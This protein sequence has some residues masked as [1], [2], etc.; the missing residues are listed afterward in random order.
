M[1]EKYAAKFLKQQGYK[2]LE[3]NYRNKLGE[4]DLIA[5]DGGEIVF[6]EVKA[7]SADP[8]LSGQYAVDRK[9][10]F[11]ILRTAARYLDEKRT[12][13]QPRFDVVEVEID[14]STGKL[15]K[16]GHF[17]AAFTQTESYARF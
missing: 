5:R 8:Y 11:H 17:R 9:K 3:K 10:Q 14:R 2:I 15:V 16:I 12:E 13:L 6:V 7:R 1:G 4:I